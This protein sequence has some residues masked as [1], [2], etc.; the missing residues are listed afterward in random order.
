MNNKNTET[1]GAQPNQPTE[2]TGAR[3]DSLSIEFAKTR[4]AIH[5]HT[6]L[7][8]DPPIHEGQNSASKTDE[9]GK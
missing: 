6:F 2:S 8:I 9:K 3:G 7:P 1:P 5:F 4:G